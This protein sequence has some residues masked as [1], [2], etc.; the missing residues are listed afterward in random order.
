MLDDQQQPVPPGV[1]GELWI[2][3][4]GVTRGYWQRPDLTA[5]RFRPDPFT[6]AGRGRMYRTGDLVRLRGM[7][8]SITSGEA[9]IRSSC[10]AI[11]SSWARLKARW[12][13]CRA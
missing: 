9:T 13:P 11:G 3:G 12:K 7:A 2:G 5:D 6:G 1:A 4:D 10:A 8:S